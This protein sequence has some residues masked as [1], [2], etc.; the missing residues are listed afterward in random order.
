[1]FSSRFSIL[2]SYLSNRIAIKKH[3]SREEALSKLQ[4]YCAYR[5]RCRQEIRQKL[6]SL[7][8]WGEHADELMNQLAD[9]RY[10]DEFRFAQVYTSD[11]FRLKR[12]GRKKIKQGLQQKQVPKAF[13]E[14]ALKEE[15]VV[16]DYWKT[17]CYLAE[18][19]RKTLKNTENTLEVKQK[20][21]RFLLQKGYEYDLIQKM[22]AELDMDA[23]KRKD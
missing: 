5:E 14:Q 12:W 23:E 7:G 19:K 2:P 10:W 22:F 21:T 11:K 13:I 6:K 15:I 8:Y 9:E 20:M 17:L 4:R 16:E 3:L 1:M 18:K